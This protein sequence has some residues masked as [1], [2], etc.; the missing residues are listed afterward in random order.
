MVI[1]SLLVWISDIFFYG[2]GPIRDI[3]ELCYGKCR[4]EF[5]DI[6]ASSA[7]FD[8]AVSYHALGLFSIL[9]EI[10]ILCDL[11]HMFTVRIP[12]LIAQQKSDN[13]IL[14][15]ALCAVWVG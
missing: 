10:I 7:C 15:A 1:L 4:T 5:L 3:I 13:T 2:N 12:A 8:R 9:Y 6:M 14:P 11:G